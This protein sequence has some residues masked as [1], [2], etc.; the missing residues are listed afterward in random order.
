[1]FLA[2][3]GWINLNVFFYEISGFT[4][5]IV[6]G[7]NLNLIVSYLKMAGLPYKNQESFEAVRW[8]GLTAGVWTIGFVIKFFVVIFGNSLYQASE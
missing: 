6:V 4:A 1:M 7:L 3:F 2:L 8:I 5:A